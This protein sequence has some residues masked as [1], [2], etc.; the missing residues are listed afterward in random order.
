MTLL[1]LAQSANTSDSTFKVVVWVGALIALTLLGG[2]GVLLARRKLLSKSTDAA[3]DTSLMGTLRRMRDTGQ[4]SDAEYESTRK[5]MVK[6]TVAHATKGSDSKGVQ[7]PNTPR[8]P[9]SKA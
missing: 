2:L 9:A 1:L 3:D 7:P 6:R 5:A 8:P 4:I